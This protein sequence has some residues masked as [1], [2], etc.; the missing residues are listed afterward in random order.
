MLPTPSPPLT[1]KDAP[2]DD[3]QLP[4]G[5]ER[6]VPTP[7]RSVMSSTMPPLLA[8]GGAGRRQEKDLEGG[9]EVWGR[10]WQGGH[11]CGGVRRKPRGRSPPASLHE[12][13]TSKAERQA[14]RCLRRRTIQHLGETAPRLPTE[15]GRG[16]STR[17]PQQG[18]GRRGPSTNFPASVSLFRSQVGCA[19]QQ[20]PSQER[21]GGPSVPH[22]RYTP[23]QDL[24]RVSRAEPGTPKG[25]G[26]RHRKAR[27]GVTPRNGPRVR[28]TAVTGD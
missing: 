2:Q 10:R 6:H 16:S 13:K 15:A 23:R 1:L 19:H 26:R 4:E 5:R 12:S 8:N 11:T 25:I 22:T 24:R 18:W 9:A 3:G 7:P 17:G 28:P 27:I 21:L 14:A 20:S